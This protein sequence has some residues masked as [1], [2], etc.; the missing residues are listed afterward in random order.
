MTKAAK[1]GSRVTAEDYVAL[2]SFRHALRHFLHFSEQAAR[3][4]GLSA[5]QHQALLVVKALSNEEEVTVGSLA[6]AL[7]L[8]H[9]STVGMV[10]RLVKKRLLKRTPS[11]EDRRKVFIG[12]TAQGEK[13]IEALS[14]AHR[15][16]LRRIGPELRR[17]LETID[18]SK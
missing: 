6:R 2:G 11:T 10:D 16:E 13:V 7:I 1:R 14:A 18:E 8:Q 3:R 5:P 9:H 17:W 12:L 15:H 4:A